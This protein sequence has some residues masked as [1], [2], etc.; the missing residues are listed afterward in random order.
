MAHI[1]KEEIAK[2]ESLKA[3]KF[4]FTAFQ[5]KKLK[6]TEQQEIKKIQPDIYTVQYEDFVSNP[7]AFIN[8]ILEYVHLGP[9]KLIDKFINKLS[10]ANRN[11]R[12]A[13]NTHTEI[14]EETKKQILELIN[15]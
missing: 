12:K 10:I 4:L 5:Y 3:N 2:A 14:T 11:N 9:S 6:E 15:S 13:A 7:T 8:G 1:L